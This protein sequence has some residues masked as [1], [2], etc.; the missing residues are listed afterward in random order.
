[1]LVGQPKIEEALPRFLD[2]IKDAVLVAHN[3]SFDVGFIIEKAKQLG[4]E[5]P[6]N[7]VIDTLSL[8]RYYYH[9]ELKRFNLK[10]VTKLFKVNLDAHHRAIS[11]AYA[12]AEVFLIM[13]QNLYKE[14]IMTYYEI[15]ASLDEDEVWKHPLTY[16]ATI[17]AQN[18]VGYKNLFKI[19]SDALTTHY[20][21]GVRTLKSVIRKYRQGILVGSN[22]EFGEVFETALNRNEDDLREVMEFYD[23]IEV[24]PPKA[25]QHLEKDL[26]E[27]GREIL[28]A[29][30]QKIIRIGKE[31]GKLVIAT[32]NA[33]YSSPRRKE[34]S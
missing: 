7:P 32:S 25:Y 3:A 8:A 1:M 10:A 15:N 2:F 9:K 33:H 22:S 27:F 26:G 11:D 29:T 6:D 21:G 14:E 4:L 5:V 30:V 31:M 17:L 19:I 18:Q 13:L 28:Q 24:H 34:R 20:Y 16:Y 23:Y 12:T